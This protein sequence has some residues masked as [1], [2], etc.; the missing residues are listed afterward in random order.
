MRLDRFLQQKHVS[1]P[2]DLLN[3]GGKWNQCR[4]KLKRVN[5]RCVTAVVWYALSY[6]HN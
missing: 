5:R 3:G 1:L 6:I 4:L 2:E